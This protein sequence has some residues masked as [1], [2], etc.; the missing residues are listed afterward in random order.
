MFCSENV[1]LSQINLVP[2]VFSVY[3]HQ[4]FVRIQVPLCSETQAQ[5]VLWD[6]FPWQCNKSIRPDSYFPLFKLLLMLW[7]EIT[8]WSPGAAMLW[9][10]APSGDDESNAETHFTSFE[11]IT[12][13]GTWTLK[14]KT[15]K[16]ETFTHTHTYIHYNKY[17]DHHH[18]YCHATGKDFLS[19]FLI[20]IFSLWLTGL[21]LCLS[22]TADISNGVIKEDYNIQSVPLPFAVVLL[23]TVLYSGA[24]V[25]KGSWRNEVTHSD[26]VV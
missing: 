19:L 12:L 26:S 23:Y 1:I 10:T 25:H 21:T 2:L 4:A 17:L 24:P 20:Q 18:L 6:S 16:E 11:V 5:T 7:G 3:L 8:K 15:R 13:S 22:A 14:V 9:S